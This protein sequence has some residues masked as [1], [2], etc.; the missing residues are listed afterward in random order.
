[1]ILA[2]MLLILTPPYLL[3]NADTLIVSN[4][5]K[6]EGLPGNSINQI[7]QDDNGFLWLTSYFGLIHFDG[8]HFKALDQANTPEFSNNR[9]HL[10]H[11]TT[12]GTLWISF[13]RR[14]LIRYDSTGFIRYDSKVG[15][16]DE[17][18]TAMQT[19]PDGRLLVGSYDG[20]YVLNKP[21]DRFERL[22]L[23]QDR[24]RNHV[25]GVFITSA[26]Q[27]WV[28][29][30][31]G[32]AKLHGNEVEVFGTGH[33]TDI[34][35]DARGAVWIGRPDGLWL[36]NSDGSVQRPAG[37]PP[38]L[39]STETTSLHKID[40]RLLVSVLGVAYLWDGKRFEQVGGL[41]IPADD[42]IASVFQDSYGVTSVITQ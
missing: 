26:K 18:I 7:A 35:E 21:S 42:Q 15:L 40:T 41:T 4:W 38:V 8:V 13:E 9:L 22:D 6:R 12:D 36:L 34:V 23:G 16:G 14:G 11:K 5:T 24:A 2:L 32:Y 28:S 33:I 20:L 3:P 30:V 31:N 39:R 1:M 37:L 10:F 29:T 27:V 25:N 17:H 19:L